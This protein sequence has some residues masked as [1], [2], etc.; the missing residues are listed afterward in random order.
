MS[1]DDTLGAVVLA[2]GLARRMGGV[3]KGL[4]PLGG[5]PMIEHVLGAVRP[6][7]DALVVN[8]NRSTDAYAAIARDHDA[9]L[10]ADRHAGH[11]GPLAGLAAGLHALDTTRAFLCPC[12]SPFVDA[13]LVA[14]LAE[15]CTA[16]D[17]DIAVAHDGERL[18]PVFCVVERRLLD[19][20]EAF[21][22]AG[23]RK[24]DR[25]YAGEAMRA[26][27]C[28]DLAVSFRNVN[29]EEERAAA[30]ATLVTRDAPAPE[31]AGGDA[32]GRAR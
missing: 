1:A 17:V 13:A 11:L 27:D 20:L 10:V 29:T 3:D 4:V 31:R 5:R 8:A 12:D 18:Q 28:A 14:R 7:V 23:E 25:W 21:L 22:E 30:E 24:I 6:A 19:S 16:P 9:T 15:A 2:G 32:D 26:V